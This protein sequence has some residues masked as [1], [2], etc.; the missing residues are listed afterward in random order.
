MACAADWRLRADW[1]IIRRYFFL[2]EP[3]TGLDPV[4]RIAVWEMLD[5]LR[6]T[7]NL[8][9]LLTTHYMDEADKLSSASPSSTT[10]PWWPWERPSS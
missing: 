1:S 3:T 5:N 8:T 4:S 9:M 7:R 2:D 10:A 6:N